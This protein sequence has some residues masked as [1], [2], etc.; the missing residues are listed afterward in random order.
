MLLITLRL[1]QGVENLV[2]E[3]I[4]QSPT[5]GDVASA[6][7]LHQNYPGATPKAEENRTT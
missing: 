5:D 3:V 2:S 6:T 4:F 7:A 1:L